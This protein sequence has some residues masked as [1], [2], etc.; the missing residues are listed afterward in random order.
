[1]M[2][3]VR[4]DSYGK[5]LHNKDLPAHMQKPI[6]D[7]HGQSMK[8]K[9]EIFKQYKFVIAFE[10]S[11]VEDYVSE[12]IMNVLQAGAVPIYQG[13][14]NIHEW[15]PSSD[16]F[17]LASDFPSA[18]EL[19]EYINRLDQNTEEYNKHLN[20]K[21]HGFAPSFIDKYEKCIFRDSECRLCK[22]LK[23]LNTA[24]V[25]QQI[26]APSLSLQLDGSAFVQ[27]QMNSAGVKIGQFL[28]EEFT[29]VG[30]IKMNGVVRDA[31]VVDKNTPFTLDGF[32]LD[33]FNPDDN[34]LRGFL[35]L[36]GP[37]GCFSW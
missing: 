27:I 32:N 5:C 10:N 33:I 7:D 9:I 6:Y 1:M 24:S 31:R 18:K 4:V 21:K 8:N 11:E 17:I 37:D 20:W 23:E 2:K 12:K 15:M 36:C 34:E 14:P 22:R 19:A 16:S 13:A 29:I 35:R 3:Y 28:R 30:W 25:A 26:P